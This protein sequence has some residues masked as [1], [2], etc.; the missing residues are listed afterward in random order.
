MHTTSGIR[1][2]SG[3]LPPN[4]LRPPVVDGEVVDVVVVTFAV[5]TFGGSVNLVA[6]GDFDATAGDD[7]S[8]DP[9]QPA[10]SAVATATRQANRVGPP[11]VWSPCTQRP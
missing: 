9:A 4:T 3:L 5:V 11:N 10:T 1:L 8:L 7:R 2:S 6:E